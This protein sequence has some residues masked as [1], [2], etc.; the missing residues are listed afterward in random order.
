MLHCKG[1][2]CE[3]SLCTKDEEGTQKGEKVKLAVGGKM[4]EKNNMLVSQTVT[5]QRDH[6]P[7]A[8][9]D[10][11]MARGCSTNGEVSIPRQSPCVLPHLHSS[12]G[13]VL[14]L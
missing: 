12:V 1:A 4:G 11:L 13:A 10:P 9:S 3:S 7:A 14:M 6:K 8:T 5:Y 2:A